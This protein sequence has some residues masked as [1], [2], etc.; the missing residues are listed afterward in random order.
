VLDS[1]VEGDKDTVDA[2]EE[3]SSFFTENTLKSRRNPRR[4]I[5]R[6]NLQINHDFLDAF[7]TVKESADSLHEN[8]SAMSESCKAM[9][10]RGRL[11]V[12]KSV[13]H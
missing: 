9:Q 11:A 1:R 4:E 6:R 13:T 10:A 12:S 3:L 2:L 5:E 7:R 8:V